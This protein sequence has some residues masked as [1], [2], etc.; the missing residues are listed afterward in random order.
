MTER[1]SRPEVR[2]PILAMPEVM[3]EFSALPP[4]A[5]QA[6]VRMLSKMSRHFHANGDAA[7]DKNKYYV[8]GYWK[9]WGVY[10]RHASLAGRA[11]EAQSQL[12]IIDA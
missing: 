9:G 4:E 7:W 2:N 5:R 11:A 3:E 12:E 1:S 8:A 10:A 6:L